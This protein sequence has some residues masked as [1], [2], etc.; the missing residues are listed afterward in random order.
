[1]QTA[2][3]GKT[4]LIT[5]GGTGLGAAVTRRLTAAGAVVVITGRRPEP[6][7]KVAA[8]TGAIP[9]TGDVTRAEDLARAVDA[10]VRHGGGLQMMVANAGV[11][12]TGDGVNLDENDWQRMLDINLT[13]V[14]RTARAAIPAM[15]KSGGGS[16]V[17]VSSVAGLMGVGESAAYCT[18]KSALL[19]LTRSLA[20]DY[21]GDGIRV[22]TLCPGWF[23][24]EMSEMEMAALA[25]EKNISVEAAIAR[26][27]Q[28]LPLKRMASP[29][30]IA[31]CAAFLLSDDASF[32]T[33]TVL[34]ADGGG[35]I[36]DVGMLGFL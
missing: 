13:G 31:A 15:K 34:V 20:I 36:V 2:M 16:I 23:R 21:G 1:M 29:D 26:V 35:A 12:A 32:V 5:G 9:V 19:G 25:R 28:H 30:E 18:T 7:Q 14:M 22:N 4:A 33:G 17:L 11:I 24:S 6:L 10:A 8:D 3:T 27:T